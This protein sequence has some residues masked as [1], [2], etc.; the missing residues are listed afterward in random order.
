MRLVD[1]VTKRN[2][3]TCGCLTTTEL[4]RPLGLTASD[5]Y[6]ELCRLGVLYYGQR[7]YVLT[8]EYQYR[9]LMQY[10]HFVYFTKKGERK[11]KMYPVWTPSGV[12]LFRKMIA[13]NRD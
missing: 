10:R 1:A 2:E 5:V 8:L 11:Q 9:G 13:V 12:E 4:G 3:E 7:K 6:K